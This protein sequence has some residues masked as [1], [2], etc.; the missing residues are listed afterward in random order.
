MQNN[1]NS[2]TGEVVMAL[3]GNKSDLDPALKKIPLQ[4][5]RELSK[6]HNMIFAET[7]AKSNEG[8]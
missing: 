3:A 6:K 7:S 8:I 1:N 5:A 2:E 4:T